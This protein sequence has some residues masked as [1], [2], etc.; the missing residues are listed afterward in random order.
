MLGVFLLCSAS[1]SAQVPV[2]RVADDARVIDRVAEATRKDLPEELLKRIINEDIDLL[3]GKRADGSY[4]YATFERLEA[5][6]TANDFS[7]QK[8]KE[9]DLTHIEL[10]GSWVY[11]V[12]LSLP[13]RRLIV[14]RN[15]RV[16]VDR[17]DLEFIP[18]N[19]SSTKTQSVK[20][21][22]WMEPGASTPI[23][24][25]VVARQATVRVYA[26]ADQDA[27]Y[28]N[29]VLTL[30]HA[31]IVD[32]V[33][34]PYAAA[35]SSAKA[36]LRA[37]EN[38]EIPSIR[39]MAVRLHDSLVGAGAAPITVTATSPGPAAEIDVIPPPATD[40]TE[41]HNELQEIEDLLTG[42]ENERRQGL[43]RLHQL[44]RKTRPR[45]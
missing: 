2:Q 33:D 6:R 13:S 41:M 1:L 16:W 24:F 4:R 26:R 5:G 35:V 32:N 8:R 25:P 11:R 45:T 12:I 28:G 17:V 10:K 39:A 3:R 40:T 29:V 18:E 30:V 7:I 15:R 14:T 23:D 43:D 20:I 19:S 9:E 34:S 37:V 44:V 31:K 21:E 36:L 27:G 22:A 42:N 38:N